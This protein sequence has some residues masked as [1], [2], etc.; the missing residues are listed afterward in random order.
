MANLKSS[1]KRIKTNI[2]RHD[3]NVAVKTAIKTVV[4][5]VEQAIDEGNLETAQASYSEAISALDSAATK[6]IIKKNSASRKKARLA[7]RI[8]A[9][10]N[11]A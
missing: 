1:K 11:A 3:R 8:N 9:L 2:K 4:K 5:N 6:G 7:K 10:K